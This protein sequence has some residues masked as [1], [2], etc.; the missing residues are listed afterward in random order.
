MNKNHHK[1]L[2]Q[3]FLIIC[4][5]SKCTNVYQSTTCLKMMSKYIE[6]YGKHALA[7]NQRHPKKAI[8]EAILCFTYF[9]LIENTANCGYKTANCGYKT[10]N[11]GFYCGYS[12]TNCG[13]NTVNSGYN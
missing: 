8:Q 5:V 13:Y 9:R 3:T 12:T 1:E 6:S 7:I 2:F 4:D 11:C 10:A